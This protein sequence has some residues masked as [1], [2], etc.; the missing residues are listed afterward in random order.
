MKSKIASAEIAYQEIAFEQNS[1]CKK[2]LEIVI[3]NVLA[4]DWEDSQRSRGTWGIGVGPKKANE[5]PEGNRW[6]SRGTLVSWGR[7]NG[8][9]LD[10]NIII[11]SWVH[12]Y[13]IWFLKRSENEF[14]RSYFQETPQKSIYNTLAIRFFYDW[15]PWYIL[16]EF[17]ICSSFCLTAFVTLPFQH[18]S[19][20]G[21]C[22]F[23]RA[24]I[25]CCCYFVHLFKCPC[26]F[27]RFYFCSCS[28]VLW[29]VV[30]E[31][32]FS[33]SYDFLLRKDIA[34]VKKPL[35]ICVFW[36]EFSCELR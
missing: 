23:K 18:L 26:C 14:Y 32:A 6:G 17:I 21:I 4:F 16:N 20:F 9:K 33:N 19:Y 29:P 8:S 27:V 30:R 1:W 12:N 5:G 10:L 31:R 11:L 13:M 22:Y 2:Q 35:I 24:V 15:G 34:S 36:K 3:F 7:L 28:S 25:F